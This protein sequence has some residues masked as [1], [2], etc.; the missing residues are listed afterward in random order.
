[1]DTRVKP[2][3]DW[4]PIPTAPSA[5]GWGN[6]VA[7]FPISNIGWATIEGWAAKRSLAWGKK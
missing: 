1:M 4:L 3:I 5:M 6:K 7:W 2:H